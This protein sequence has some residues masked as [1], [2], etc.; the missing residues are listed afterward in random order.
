MYGFVKGGVS[1]IMKQNHEKNQINQQI[2]DVKI[3]EIR[4]DSI[5]NLNLPQ[6]RSKFPLSDRI[7]LSLFGCCQPKLSPRTQ[8]RNTPPLFQFDEQFLRDR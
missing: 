5:P 3:P 4:E 6:L 2:V 8:L 1:G 7:S